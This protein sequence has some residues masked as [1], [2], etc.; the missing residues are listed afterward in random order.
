MCGERGEA[1]LRIVVGI[2]TGI[3]LGVWRILIKLLVVVHLI[4][5]VITGKR[6]KDLADFCEIWNTQVYIFLKYITFVTNERPFPFTPLRK[7]VTKF[8]KKLNK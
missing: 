5:A 2:V 1:L 4:Y 6:I 3:I 7:N 8:D